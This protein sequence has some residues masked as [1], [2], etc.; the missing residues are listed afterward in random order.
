MNRVAA[1]TTPPG[2]KFADVLVENAVHS[3]VYNSMGF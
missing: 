1:K 2:V 3:H